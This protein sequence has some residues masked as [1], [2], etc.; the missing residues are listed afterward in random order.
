MSQE[1]E[2]ELRGLLR[3]TLRQMALPDTSFCQADPSC[4]QGSP[5]HPLRGLV[6]ASMDI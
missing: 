4:Q 5:S 2:V 3:T 6:V 1:A